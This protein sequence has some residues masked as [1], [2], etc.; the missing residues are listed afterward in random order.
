MNYNW[1]KE[2]KLKIK[3]EIFF[4]K[5]SFKLQGIKPRLISKQ[6]ENQNSKKEV[7]KGKKEMIKMVECTHKTKET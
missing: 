1:E 3:N 2:D 4:G 7:K 6:K 5:C